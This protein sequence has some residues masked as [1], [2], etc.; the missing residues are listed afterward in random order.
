MSKNP[1]F[2]LIFIGTMLLI[3]YGSPQLIANNITD[4]QTMLEDIHANR[5]ND[6]ALSKLLPIVRGS[7]QS[8][9]CETLLMTKL[10]DVNTTMQE[11]RKTA[12]I[13][14]GLLA[15]KVMDNLP[16]KHAE[17][18]TPIANYTGLQLANNINLL[19]VMRSGDALLEEFEK[20]FPQAPINKV[21]VQRNELTAEPD[22]KYMK[23]SPALGPNSYVIITEPMLAT[24]GTLGMVLNLLKE[25]GV[26]EENVIIA[27][28]C[29]APEGLLV[30]N[31]KFPKI[32]VVMITMDD[33]LNERKYIVP[34]IGDF[35]DRYFGTVH[36]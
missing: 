13:L 2:S 27:C 26:Q 29:T 25:R 36:Q 34:G 32:N 7:F 4:A 11:F 9:K 6:G 5:N 28:V 17:I 31:H 14:A 24:G 21:L 16:T 3:S 20:F 19:S 23:L 15:A 33:H 35:G 8:N 12:N 18:K 1:F 10:R 30:L 22:F